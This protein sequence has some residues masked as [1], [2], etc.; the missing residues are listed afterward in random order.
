MMR[1]WSAMLLLIGL[2]GDVA[3]PASAEDGPPRLRRWHVGVQAASTWRNRYDVYGEPDLPASEVSNRGHGGG[4][5]IGC[6]FGDRFLLQGQISVA[7]HDLAGSAAEVLDIEALLTGTVLFRPRS[8]L[9]PFLRGGVGGGGEL[10]E[11]TAGGDDLFAFGTT[12]VAGGGLQVRLGSRVSLEWELVATFCNL[13]E[14]HNADHNERW[15]DESW[16]V[17]VSNWGWRSGVGVVVWF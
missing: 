15:P 6:R 9:Q 5:V 13:L 7:A 12:A 3:A 14:V 10:L 11:L 4:G 16:Q 2:L 1:R 8:T 17:R